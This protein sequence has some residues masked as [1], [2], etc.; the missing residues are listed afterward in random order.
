MTVR[1][2]SEPSGGRNSTARGVPIGCYHAV[3]YDISKG[4]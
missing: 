4:Y 3:L 2:A 1:G